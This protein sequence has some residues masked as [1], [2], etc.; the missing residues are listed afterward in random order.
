MPVDDEISG[1]VSPSDGVAVVAYIGLGSN[2]GEKAATLESAIC[3]IAR[4][5][6]TRVIARSDWMQ[7]A[8]VGVTDQPDFLNGVIAIETLLPS[9]RLIGEL[10]RIEAEHGRDRATV[11]RWGPRTLDLDLLLYGSAMIDEPG[12]QVP[13]PRMFEREFVLAPLAQIAAQARIPGYGHTVA[14]ALERLRCGD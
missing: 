9:R 3:Q 1:Q 11:S 8:P 2:L 13:H 14:E 4:L 12:L 6:H 10:L 5:P 7:T